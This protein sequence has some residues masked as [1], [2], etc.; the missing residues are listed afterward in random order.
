MKLV[1]QRPSELT[2][3]W[4]IYSIH[5]YVLT[6]WSVLIGFLGFLN[7]QKWRK[8]K[9]ALENEW[10]H[11]FCIVL[12]LCYTVRVQPVVLLLV[13]TF[14]FLTTVWH[15]E[16]GIQISLNLCV[17]LFTDWWWNRSSLKIPPQSL[18]QPQSHHVPT[19]TP[20]RLLH[21][22]AAPSEERLGHSSHQCAR[23]LSRTLS[24][25][26]R[27]GERLTA[28]TTILSTISNIKYLYFCSCFSLKHW[29]G[30]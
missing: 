13:H 17:S 20:A 7:F 1:G 15:D 28:L 23:E 6:A 2:W 24:T 30:Y 14:F 9:V 26:A 25:N 29:E 12:H 11:I 5:P 8:R 19:S 4:C 3:M 10:A 18:L 21:Q 22:W 27:Q 16:A